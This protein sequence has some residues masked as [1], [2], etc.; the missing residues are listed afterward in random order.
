MIPLMLNLTG[1]RVIIFGGGDVGRRKAAFFL[2]ESDVRVVSRSFHPD[3]LALPVTVMTRDL[4]TATDGDIAGLVEGAFLAVA[5]TSDPGL[6]NRIGEICREKGVLFNNADGQEGD[7]LLPAVARGGEYCIAVSTKGSSPAVA[8]WLRRRI[9][10][11]CTGL[12]GMIMLQKELRGMLKE[13][14]GSQQERNAILRDLLD[15]E[16]IWTLVSRDI[17]S[18]R[19]L[20]KRKYLP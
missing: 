4:G 1:R 20:M 12:D 15:D 11:E 7:V 17:S 8:R 2:P 6:N 10:R 19:A 14:N 18:A 3:V 13:K 5:A 16:E 9:E